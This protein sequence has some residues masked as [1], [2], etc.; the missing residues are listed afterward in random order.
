MQLLITP[1]RHCGVALQ[2]APAK[3]TAVIRGE[4][5][6]ADRVCEQL[7]RHSIVASVRPVLGAGALLLPE[8]FDVTLSAMAREGFTLSGIEFDGERWYAQSWWCRPC[9]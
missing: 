7:N 6:I 2:M 4:L 8:M 3:R 1:R 9:Q 5:I